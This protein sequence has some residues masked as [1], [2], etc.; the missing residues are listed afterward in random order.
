MTAEIIMHFMLLF[1]LAMAFGELCERVKLP[2]LLGQVAAGVVMGPMM[3]GLINP[4]DEL[5]TAL[6]E[7]GVILL[8]FVVGFKHIDVES[9]FKNRGVSMKISAVS[10]SMPALGVILLA[11][12]LGYELPTALMLGVALSATSMSISI[13]SITEVG[14]IKSKAGETIIGSLIINDITGLM[15]L[16]LVFTYVSI[17]ASGAVGMDMLFEILLVIVSVGLFFFIFMMSE[18]IFPYLI[19]YSS[20]LR[21]EEAQFTVALIIIFGFSILAEQLKLSTIIGALFAGIALSHSSVLQVRSYYDKVSSISNGF[22][23]PFFFAL[24]GARMS[25]NNFGEAGGIALMLLAIITTIQIGGAG[26]IAKLCGFNIRDALLVGLGM[27]PYG[28]VT[29]VVMSAL[30]TMR[31][32]NPAMFDPL[33][34]IEKLFSAVILLITMSVV[35]APVLMKVVVGKENK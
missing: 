8:L 15:L 30:L 3:L 6:S 33:P 13:R 31:A 7:V 1:I 23:I 11:L 5:Y 29:L 10:S 20:K 12:Y 25:F 2:S 17:T 35:I 14:K 34:M 19:K 28:E 27:L 26:T 9:L 24:V 22:F 18:E 21:M 16:T 4:N 32:A